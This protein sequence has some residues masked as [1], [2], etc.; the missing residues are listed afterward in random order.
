[1]LGEEKQSEMKTLVPKWAFALRDAYLELLEEKNN[2]NNQITE[3]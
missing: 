1:M 3:S 2:K